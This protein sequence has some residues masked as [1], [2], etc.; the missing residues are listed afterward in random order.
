[1]QGETRIFTRLLRWVTGAAAAR[2][3]PNEARY[4]YLTNLVAMQAL[5]ITLFYIGLYF[6]LGLYE[7]FA[8][9][10]PL[11]LSSIAAMALN[12]RGAMSTAKHLLL[13]CASFYIFL[14]ASYLGP[15]SEIQTTLF[16]CVANTFLVFSL[17]Q[18]PHM[19]VAVAQPL[20]YFVLIGW[21]QVD[22]VPW[23]AAPDEVVMLQGIASRY[24]TAFLLLVTL[25]VFAFTTQRYESIANAASKRLQDE[26]AMVR[27]LQDVATIANHAETLQAAAA[28]AAARIKFHTGWSGGELIDP[29]QPG[30]HHE[31][32]TRLT[33]VGLGCWRL[34][35]DTGQIHFGLAIAASGKTIAAMVF[36]VPN[37]SPP[38]TELVESLDNV[39]RQLGILAERERAR[40]QVG[41]SHMKMIAAAKM[42]TLGEM[43]GGI[44]HEINNPLAVIQG[45]LARIDRHSGL[46]QSRPIVQDAVLNI[47]A[48]I[49]RITKIVTGLRSFARDSGADPYETVRLDRVISDTLALSAERFKNR[50]IS[51][52]VP[53]VPPDLFVDCRPTQIS[54]V[55]LNLLN[56]AYD[57]VAGQKDK[58]I[59]LTI[60]DSEE[61][62]VLGVTDSGPGI[63]PEISAKIL[64]PFFTTKPVG[65]GTGLGLSISKGL[66]ESH[67]G[68]LEFRSNVGVGTHFSVRLP[69]RQDRDMFG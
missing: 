51:L 1:M 21:F 20:A 24:L 32:L 4:I 26:M 65:Q 52:V 8:F 27:L 18:W 56:N 46:P 48:T 66:V 19:V 45:Y 29:A 15:E 59:E 25:V 43:A 9:L 37:G 57:A 34:S 22:W 58:R 3:Y 10:I 55:L 49:Q 62:L 54:Q 23:H 41:E 42:A 17:R 2:R 12:N 63:P 7:A 5:V 36:E 11:A 30:Q 44:A 60:A 13:S 64:E 53:K 28:D 61:E 69:K 68:T 14:Y 67:G 16:S 50:G 38:S 47:N 6:R 40:D 39:G 35:P 31:L 33:N